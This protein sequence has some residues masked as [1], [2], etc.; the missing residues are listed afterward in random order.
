MK[1]SR[2]ETDAISEASSRRTSRFGNLGCALFS[3]PFFFAGV[4]LI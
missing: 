1:R 3:L 2:R 4:A